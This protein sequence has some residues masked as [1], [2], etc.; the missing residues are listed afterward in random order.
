M[1]IRHRFLLIIAQPHHVRFKVKEYEQIRYAFWAVTVCRWSK[2]ANKLGVTTVKD[3]LIKKRCSI[4][5]A[6][7]W[8]TYFII[9]KLH[10]NFF[11]KC[12]P[13]MLLLVQNWGKMK[14]LPQQR[15]DLFWKFHIIFCNDTLS[16]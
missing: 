4:C 5:S 16:S 11:K 1:C 2:G 15:R 3:S 12:M 14:H 8:S 9:C 10:E 7:H 6:F 13:V